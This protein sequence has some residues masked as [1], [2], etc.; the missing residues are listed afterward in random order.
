MW[1]CCL[2]RQREKSITRVLGHNGITRVLGHNGIEF[3]EK[4]IESI[5]MGKPLQLCTLYASYLSSTRNLK[6]F[7]FSLQIHQ[8]VQV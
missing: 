4:M 8:K 3:Q 1:G 5:K 2:H 7:V 6:N